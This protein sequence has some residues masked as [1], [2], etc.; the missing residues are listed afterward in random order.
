MPKKVLSHFQ[1]SDPILYAAIISFEGELRSG[2]EVKTDLF[3]SLCRT[4]VGQQLS[5]KAAR[6]IWGK[7]QLLFPRNKP[8][9]TNILEMSDMRLRESGLSFAKIRALRDLSER[10]SNR[11]L[12][13]SSLKNVPENKAR[14]ELQKV[15]GI[16]PWSSEMFLMFAL[17]REDVFS[18]GDLGL[19]KGIQKIYGHSS[20]PSP[21]IV[22]ELSINWSPYKTYAACA[23]WSILDNE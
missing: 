19:K 5:G 11:S 18:P 7:F 13:L 14:E 10:I 20:L 9:A 8:T 15:T 12:R 22:E 21:E 16:G 3:A 17:G 6:S 1:K 2:P 23:I 4:I